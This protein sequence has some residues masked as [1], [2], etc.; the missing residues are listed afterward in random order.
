MHADT[1]SFEFS[2]HVIMYCLM[3]FTYLI[4][5]VVVDPEQLISS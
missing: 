2:L 3:M 4:L 1:F 5:H